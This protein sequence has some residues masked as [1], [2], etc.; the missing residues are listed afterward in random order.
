MGGSFDKTNELKRQLIQQ[1]ATESIEASEMNRYEKAPLL[2]S[3][4]SQS[5]PYHLTEDY[6]ISHQLYHKRI[7]SEDQTHLYNLYHKLSKN[8]FQ[9][10]T[11]SVPFLSS[12]YGKNSLIVKYKNALKNRKELIKN[13]INNRYNILSKVK[14]NIDDNNNIYKEKKLTKLEMMHNNYWDIASRLLVPSTSW[15]ELNSSMTYYLDID[16]E[17]KWN[18]IKIIQKWVRR[19]IINNFNYERSMK[20]IDDD[21]RLKLSH[22][23]GMLYVIYIKDHHHHFHHHHHH[24]HPH[25]FY[26]NHLKHRMHIIYTYKYNIN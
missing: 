17:K 4:L 8:N 16:Y 21:A 26:L 14:N 3:T 18:A 1:I 25:D 13:A 24:S 20:I 9:V 22:K 12:I 2:L 23:V 10:N 6:I 11:S 15:R 19:F 5:L 7:L